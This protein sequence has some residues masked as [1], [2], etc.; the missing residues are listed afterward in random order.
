MTLAEALRVSGGQR[1]AFVGAGGKTTAMFALARGFGGKAVVTTSTNLLAGQAKLA[2]RH[3]S[4][5]EGQAIPTI[6]A[7]VTLISGPRKEQK[8]TAISAAQWEALSA[9]AEQEGVLLLVE[10]DGARGLAL[11]A[12]A[13]HEPALPDGI[14]VVVVCAGLSAL[15]KP[16]D[17]NA[18]HRPEM[19]SGV[20]GVEEGAAITP[21]MIAQI[22][23]HP[24]GGL[25]LPGLAEHAKRVALLNQA[26]DEV[27]AATGGKIA[28]QLLAGYDMALAASMK[29]E[30]VWSRH[31]RIAGIVLAAGGSE[32][33]GD[34]K[35]L[36]T[37]RGESFVRAVTQTALAA[38]CDPVI[39]VTGAAGDA[40][41]AEIAGLEVQIVHNPN[42]KAGQSGSM[43]AGILA[44]P[45]HA[46][47]A[48]FFLVDQPQIP[49]E[50]PRA[51]IE[52]HRSDAAQIVA[53]LADGQRANPVLFDA[54]TF[55][56]LMA[57]EGDQGGR[58]LFQRHEVRYV[59]WIDPV[60]TLDVD[61]LED[62]QRL[63]NYEDD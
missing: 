18:A 33:L 45:A 50:L 47:G 30:R 43:Q 15:G 8:L 12:P 29:E 2:D 24:Q 39:V 14:D 32:R 42:W 38:G 13:A 22:L 5:D 11:K 1:V 4:I 41:G 55:P 28:R 25:R 20:L 46:G 52:V 19:V 10:A 16:L 36:L 48:I 60:V 57:V 53:P 62:Y 54:R 37:W 63:L 27:R 35:P 44:L 58:A 49:P 61:T 34:A 6:P 51:L 23:L 9:M 26:D 7:G 31:E 21:A 3:F 17:Q 59:E 56:E 40:V